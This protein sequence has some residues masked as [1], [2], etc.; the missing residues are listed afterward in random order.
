[1]KLFRLFMAL[2]TIAFALILPT[3]RSDH[4]PSKR[5]LTLS[6]YWKQSAVPKAPAKTVLRKKRT[7][8]NDTITITGVG[9]L[10]L[11]TNYPHKYLIPPNNGKDLMADVTPLIRQADVAF[12][13]LASPVLNKGGKRKYCRDSTNCFAFR[14]PEAV[15]QNVID[16]GFDVL[17]IGN[18]HINDFGR[19]GIV[20]TLQFLRKNRIPHAGLDSI[21]YTIFEKKGIR[22]GFAAFTPYD[23]ITINMH[24][25]SRVS[26]II[27]HLDQHTDIVIVSVRAGGEGSAYQQLTKQPEHF[28]GEDRGNIYAFAHFA[29]DQ[30]ADIIFGHGPHVS[31]AIEIYKKRF[32]AYSLGNFCTYSGIYRKGVS[33]IAPIA[34]VMVNPQ[35]EFLMAQLVST[36]QLRNG[37]VIIDAQ[38]QVLKIIKRL[39]KL[40][41]PKSTLHIDNKGWVSLLTPPKK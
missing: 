22:Y 11:G 19:A 20:N 36:R 5:Q 15:A 17:N 25:S 4:Y 10:M 39:T 31:R 40:A 41:F 28:A 13:N 1:M 18:N 9:D 16:S 35:G 14:T 33:G 30:G 3:N 7:Q 27:Q 23:T 37:K 21:P 38:Q 2:V 12:G 6:K 34:R 26:S 29:I 24:D 32:I 8:T